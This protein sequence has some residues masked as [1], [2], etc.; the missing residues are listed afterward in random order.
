M[1]ANDLGTMDE[2]SARLDAASGTG[3]GSRFDCLSVLGCAAAER[4]LDMVCRGTMRPALVHCADVASFDDWS[5]I[6]EGLLANGY[7]VA[8][9]LD[10]AELYLD[11]PL[12]DPPAAVDERPAIASFDV[13]DTLI[14]RRCVEPWRVFQKV[15]EIAGLAD[16][17]AQRRAAEA[18][19]LGG[20]YR[21]D[22]IYDELARHY[23]WQADCRAEI[24]ALELRCEGE[25]V[26]PIK[27]NLARVRDGDLLVSDMYLGEEHIRSLL[28]K[29]GL[30]AQVGLFVASHAKSS[31]R[32]WPVIDK[33]FKITRHLGDNLLADI[34]MPGRFGLV[35]EQARSSEPN[36]VE[37]T[38]MQAGLRELAL[39]CREARLA[40]WHE[41]PAVRAL[42]VV[43]T[44]LN[45]PLLLLASIALA[46]R[47]KALGSTS[48]LF[49][50]RDCNLWLPLFD[51][52][53]RTMGSAFETSYFLTSRLARKQGSEAYLRYARER[54]HPGALVVDLCGTGWTLAH[55]AERLGLA[56]CNVFLVD[57][58]PPLG[59]SRAVPAD[60]VDLQDPSAVRSAAEHQQHLLRNGQ[61][62]RARHGR[63]H[64]CRRDG[65]RPR[66]RAEPAVGVRDRGC[67]G[68]TGVFSCRCR[69]DGPLRPARGL[70]SRRCLARGPLSVPLPLFGE[71]DGYVRDLHPRVPRRER[72]DRCDVDCLTHR[73]IDDARATGIVGPDGTRDERGIEGT[74]HNTEAS[75]E[76]IPASSAQ[77]LYDDDF[78]AWTQ[79]QAALL[80][81]GRLAAV[82]L[83]NVLEEIET[84]GRKEVAELR[85]RFTVLAQHLLKEM[86]QP[87]KSG[88]SWRTTIL[89]QRIEI[90]RHMKDN[91]SLKAK[92][93]SV[94]AEA[95]A[96][97]RDLAASE[98]GLAAETFP[99]APPFTRA[100]ALERSW[101]PRQDP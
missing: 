5:T 79:Q 36:V 25:T 29:A 69:L 65:T 61:H 60:T 27:E 47:A 56:S 19:L 13:F 100:Q 81:Q 96:D 49:C 72:E 18:R 75:L 16:F 12:V 87:E 50:S 21:F 74:P 11:G 22:D 14:A 39:L 73:P 97:A 31:G 51:A 17:L 43:Q 78:Y 34:T 63:G 41:D 20:N 68:T 23:G 2:L 55:L 93:D 71:A 3:A 64:A 48:L 101:L 10:G 70:R 98:T 52:L 6:R 24:Q 8:G 80:R 90:G 1:Q 32:I 44:S 45:F 84:L 53:Q 33:Q 15:G 30:T 92:A 4:A 94:F 91:P 66:L 59:R 88:R 38:F 82:D 99:E 67:P 54:L 57:H 83:P 40:S 42:Q 37:Q 85:A 35:T 28:A 58:C 86:Y 9:E 77:S 89:N 95:Y 46:R 7:L 62:G 76:D 26:I